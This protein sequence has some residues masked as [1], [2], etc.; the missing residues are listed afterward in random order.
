[1]FFLEDMGTMHGKKAFEK[2]LDHAEKNLILCISEKTYF[3]NKKERKFCEHY[4]IY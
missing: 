1:M 4:E 2:T 3:S